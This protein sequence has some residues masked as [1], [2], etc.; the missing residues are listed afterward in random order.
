MGTTAQSCRADKRQGCGNYRP[1]PWKD[2]LS[3]EKQLGWG[4]VRLQTGLFFPHTH[5]PG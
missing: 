2:T 5:H 4:P 3:A 1:S